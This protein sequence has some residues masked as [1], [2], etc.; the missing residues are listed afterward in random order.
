LRFAWADV[1]G[2]PSTALNDRYFA[3]NSYTVSQIPYSPSIVSVV[4]PEPLFLE[5][6]KP[7]RKR[8]FEA[9]L[10]TR[11]LEQSKLEVDFSFYTNNIYNEIIS[12]PTSSATG[13]P[14]ANINSGNTKHW[15]Y[16]LFVKAAPLVTDKLRW[17][18]TFTAARELSKIVTLYPGIH[19]KVYN[20]DDLQRGFRVESIEGQPAGQIQLFD[21]KRDPSGNRI[22]SSTGGYETGD[23]FK[24]FGNVNPKA[25]GGLYSDFFLKGFNFHIGID[26]K[27]GGTIFSY[28]NN[29]L[30]GNGVIKSTLANRD[31]AHGGL[32]YYI[33]KTT[34]ANVP[35]Q[36][37]SPAPP[38]AVNGLVHHDGMILDGVKEVTSGSSVK[39]EKND[40]IIP[41]I[42]YYQS[43]IND[44]GGTWPPDRLFKND[45]IK[46][47]EISVDYTI[48]KKISNMLKLQ[49]LS[50]NVAVR[51]LGYL[52][53]TLPNVDAESA[54]S[55]QGYL[56]NSFY[57][58]L[59]SY[60]FGIN[61]SF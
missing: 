45:Y 8:E 22:V 54:L 34:G 40:I 50:V 46:L 9:G 56:E 58:S 18:L 47:R 42:S 41:A 51:N 24:T 16:E 38:N 13:N 60:S 15:G 23:D 4:P 21:Y 35:W 48:P 49:K 27:Y 31:E 5:A 3:D 1:G 39:Y 14:Y 53:K 33:D 57:P 26:Y 25:Y 59:R 43:Y 10:N 2:G 37:N 44:A 61:V 20:R 29:Y 7:F 32:A 30:V 52:Y 17:E 19:E 28:S 55:A 12:L 11:W 36:H 6:I